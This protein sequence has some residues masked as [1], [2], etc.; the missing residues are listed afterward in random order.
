MTCFDHYLTETP[1]ENEYTRTGLYTV[2]S[3]AV[4]ALE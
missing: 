1:R 3:V 2:Y 4:F